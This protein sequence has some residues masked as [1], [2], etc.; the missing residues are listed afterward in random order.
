MQNAVV[1]VIKS[2]HP[3]DL[4]RLYFMISDKPP[5]DIPKAFY[6]N[7]DNVVMRQM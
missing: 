7:I 3:L 1:E 6:F 2:T 5:K 4:D